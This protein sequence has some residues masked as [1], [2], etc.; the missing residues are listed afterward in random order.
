MLTRHSVEGKIFC[1]VVVQRLTA[2]LLTKSLVDT[3]VQKRGVSGL[4]GICEHHLASHTLMREN[5]DM[6]VVF[7]DMVNTYRSVPHEMTAFNSLHVPETITQR[8]MQNVGC[9]LGKA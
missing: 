2:Y 9:Y 3:T 5:K 4:V 7:L 8:V 6:H 1:S